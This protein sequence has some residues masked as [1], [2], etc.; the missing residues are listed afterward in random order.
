MSGEKRIGNDPWDIFA[1]ITMTAI[2]TDVV[3]HATEFNNIL[4]ALYELG[5]GM[6]RYLVDISVNK[7][8][9]E[10][11]E[12]YAPNRITAAFMAALKYQAIYQTI[13]PWDYYSVDVVMPGE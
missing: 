8:T 6:K 3:I 1:A 11:Y 10:S 4:T 2:I 12:I 7:E 13:N 5:R 9:H